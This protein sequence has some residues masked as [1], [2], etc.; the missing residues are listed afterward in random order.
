MV[1]DE[2]RKQ[3]FSHYNL[4]NFYYLKIFELNEHITYL[5]KTDWGG[6]KN[7]QPNK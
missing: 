1:R 5:K 6:Q 4:I 3:T 7:K 2:W